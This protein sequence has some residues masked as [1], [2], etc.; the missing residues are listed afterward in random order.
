MVLDRVRSVTADL[1]L[2]AGRFS[3]DRPA[4]RDGVSARRARLRTL[5]QFKRDR[6]WIDIDGGLP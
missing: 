1:L 5:P 2:H 3:V 4:N 6:Q